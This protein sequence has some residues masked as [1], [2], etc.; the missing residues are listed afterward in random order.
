[1]VG[2]TNE[3]VRQEWL[4]KTLNN[5]PSGLR[6]LDAGAGELANKKYC[7]HLNYISQDFCQYEGVGDSKGLQTG[8]WE[9]KHIDIVSDITKI[10]EPNSSFDI[11][12]CSEVLEHLPNPLKALEELHRLLKT[13][14][15][16]ILSAPFC[17]L[18]H[19][20]PF[21]YST[22]FNRYFYEYHLDNLGFELDNIS[23]NG[24]Y[25]EYLGQ[26]LHRVRAVS[27]QYTGKNITQFQRL[28]ITVVLNML[29]QLSKRD[30]GS[31]ELL[32]FGY[33]VIAKKGS[34]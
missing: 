32:C 23:T 34:R 1:M 4:R 18:T 20:A 8:S 25:F 22:G 12:L 24:N 2:T 11:I 26:E 19:F 14:G 29:E 33:H 28:A 7:T 16:L 10:P 6:L 17:S 31:D 21:H 13:G 27:K 30:K 15:T 3:A 9:T 5:I